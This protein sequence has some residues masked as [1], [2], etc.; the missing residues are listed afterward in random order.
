MA[1][2]EEHPTSGHFKI[3]FRWGGKKLK[4]TLKTIDRREAEGALLRLQ[5]N[6]ALV[7]RGRLE[8]PPDADVATFLM[9]DG[10]LTE[11]PQDRQPKVKLTLG[12]LRDQDLGAHANGAVEVNSLSTMRMHLG[13]MVRTMGDK[14]AVQSLGFSQLQAHLDRRA[15]QRGHHRRP[16]SPTTLRKEMASFRA[17]WNWGVHAGLLQ[18]TFPNRGLKYPKSDEK[19]GFQ[20]WP[21]VERQ[22]NQGGLSVA[23]QR[24]LWDCVF[25]SLPEIDELLDYVRRH[26]Y[27][28]FLH[29]MFCFAAYTGARRSEMMR[30][31]IADLDLAGKV[32]VI[33]EKKRA[34]GRRTSRRVPL[35]DVLAQVLTEWLTVHPGGPFLFCHQLEVVRSKK[36]RVEHGALTR[37]EANDH[38]KRTL[39][40]GKWGQ[41]RGWHVF[42]HSFASNCAA[43]GVDQ[44]LI[45]AWLG[46]TTEEMRRRY[47]HL[48]PDQQRQALQLVFGGEAR[49]G[50]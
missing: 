38:F 31:R 47:R 29:P 6:I 22:V 48:F 25:L 18:G 12:E 30:A 46:H 10:K 1:W 20:T 9:S 2:L 41:L 36:E 15:K 5:E 32:A 3:C 8:I 28:A 33:H 19:P 23:D 21:E 50:Q 7:E 27:H 26:A 44:R 4:K 42:R 34:K 39:A 35:S 37:N 17:C 24:A 43:K 45:D 40:G 11:R 16:L 14:F 49:G 13:H